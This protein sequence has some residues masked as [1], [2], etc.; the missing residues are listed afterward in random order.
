MM[1]CSNYKFIQKLFLLQIFQKKKDKYK[2]K[3]INGFN[4]SKCINILKKLI[5]LKK[6]N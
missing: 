5:S 1:L 3:K 4:K 6:I 2:L